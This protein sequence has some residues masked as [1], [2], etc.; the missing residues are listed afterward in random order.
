MSAESAALTIGIAPMALKLLYPYHVTALTDCPIRCRT[1]GA[2][3]I[4][5]SLRLCVLAFEK[6]QQNT[7][8]NH[9]KQH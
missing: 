5:N 9:A 4:Q 2:R 8:L 7:T 1:F 6:K 3:R